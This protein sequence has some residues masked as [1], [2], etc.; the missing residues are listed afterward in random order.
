MLLN[1]LMVLLVINSNKL[2]KFNYQIP[3]IIEHSSQV[4]P[5]NSAPSLYD[6]FYGGMKYSEDYQPKNSGSSLFDTKTMYNY[7]Y[8]REG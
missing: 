4:A 3:E 5:E 6:Q 1:F 7:F 2:K 8:E